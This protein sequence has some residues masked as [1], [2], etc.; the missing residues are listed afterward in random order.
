M[1]ELVEVPVNQAGPATRIAV[2]AADEQK[3]KCIF[4]IFRR[5]AA[6]R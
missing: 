3:M 2:Q 1:G 4:R 6:G 5:V